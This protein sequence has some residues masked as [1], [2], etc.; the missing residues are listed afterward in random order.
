M[1][2]PYANNRFEVRFPLG[3]I[4][5]DLDVKY[6]KYI[7]RIQGTPYKNTLEFLTSTIK[8]I[9]IPGL[10]YTPLEQTRHR[11]RIGKFKDNKPI[12]ELIAKEFTIDFMRTDGLINYFLLY[13][14][15]I[16]RYYEFQNFIEEPIVVT[17]FDFSGNAISRYIL[18]E[19]LFNDLSDISVDNAENEQRF[20]SFTGEF[21]FNDIS[22]EI[23]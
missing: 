20:D 13:E 18:K 9:N 21:T 3:F 23:L 10:S 5:N 6:S 4:P 17:F 19:V 14:V 8:G 12:K 22:I 11:G 15:Y 7:K 2:I 1:N 16:K